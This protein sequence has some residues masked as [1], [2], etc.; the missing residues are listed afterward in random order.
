MSSSSFDVNRKQTDDDAS[1]ALTSILAGSIQSKP[2]VIQIMNT[3]LESNQ[4][5][6]AEQEEIRV[7][8]VSEGTT[9]A[10]ASVRSDV[11]EKP[12]ALT[13]SAKSVTTRSVAGSIRSRAQSAFSRQTRCNTFYSSEE[14]S[15][16]RPATSI[17]V[18]MLDNECQLEIPMPIMPYETRNAKLKQ[19]SVS[20]FCLIMSLIIT[21]TCG[22][23]KIGL[24]TALI[25]YPTHSIPF[26]VAVIPTDLEINM[27]DIDEPIATER[28]VDNA[29]FWYVSKSG[30]KF[31]GII[32]FQCLRLVEASNIGSGRAEN[33]S[34]T[35]FSRQY[36]WRLQHSFGSSL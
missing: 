19:L 35:S 36:L 34:I 15:H 30:A 17:H 11:G 13:W 4:S 7:G 12:P 6:G 2:G 10:S 24:D 29:V 1:S 18:N 14:D 9:V 22:R 26:T 5:V 3:E 28:G 25:M 33:V 20:V 23:G 16:L 27:A 32:L 8:S 21:L 31:L